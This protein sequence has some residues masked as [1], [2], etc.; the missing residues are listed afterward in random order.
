MPTL[1]PL[2]RA[3]EASLPAPQATAALPYAASEVPS[4]SAPRSPKVAQDRNI[5]LPV[6]T[7]TGNPAGFFMKFEYLCDTLHCNDDRKK[8]YLLSKL[9]GPADALVNGKGLAAL[10]LSYQELK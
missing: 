1:A 5:K 2:R 8:A 6:F 7:G 3:E 10:T 9:E 4:G